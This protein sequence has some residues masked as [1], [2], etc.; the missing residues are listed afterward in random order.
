MPQ[1]CPITTYPRYEVSDT[2]LVR[3]TETGQ[4]LKS[5]PHKKTSYPVVNL[6]HQG[7]FKKHFVHVLVLEA[8]HGPKPSPLHESGHRNGIKADCRAENLRWVTWRENYEDKLRHGTDLRGER[9]PFALLNEQQVR[10]IRA[11]PRIARQVAADYD[12]SIEAVYSIRHRR[13]WAWLD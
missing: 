2:G 5:W 9:H 7:K 1:W 3:N 13:S 4:T 11:D 8:F 12:V 10:A 6:C